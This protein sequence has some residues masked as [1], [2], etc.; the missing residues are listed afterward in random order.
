MARC[1]GSIFEVA[2]EG[3]HGL[4]CAGRE[5]KYVVGVV[6]LIREKIWCHGPSDRSQKA[7]SRMDNERQSVDH[8]MIRMP[9]RYGGRACVD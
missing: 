5:I 7:E 9:R 2:A 8:Q 1:C 4:G 6:M 3:D